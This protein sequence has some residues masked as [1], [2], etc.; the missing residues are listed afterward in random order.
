MREGQKALKDKVVPYIER[1]ASLLEVG[2]AVVADGHRLNF[3]VINPFTGKPCRAT[4]VA[5][6]DWKSWH[7]AGYVIMVEE[8]TQC[9]AAAQRN[10]IMNLGKLMKVWYTDNGKAFRAKYF[11]GC[12]SLEEAGLYG[13][14]ARLGII[15]IFARPYNAQAKIIERWNR[16]FSDTFERLF[17]SYT[18]SSILDKPAYMMRNEKFHKALHN[19]YVPTI[20]EAVDF[21]ESWLSFHRSQEC[22]NVKGKSIGAVFDEGRG[23]GVDPDELD[24]MMMETRIT[25]IDRNGIRFLNQNYY[26]DNLYGM[27]EQVVIKYSLFDLSSIKVFAMNGE[28]ICTAARVMPVHPLAGA[29]GAPADVTAVSRQIAQQKSAEKKTMEGVRELQRQGLVAQVD[30]QRIPESA[31]RIAEQCERQGIELA[32]TEEHIPEAAVVTANSGEGAASGAPTTENAVSLQDQPP[33]EAVRLEPKTRPFFGSN[34]ERYQW[35]LDF[36][37]WTDEDAAWCVWFRTTDEFRMLFAEEAAR[38]AEKENMG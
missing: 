36:G 2:D 35:H 33:A 15:H 4:L 22:P 27:R 34:I 9:I 30:W 14:S 17:P 19:E 20:E 24:D 10:C 12:K 25:R 18:G 29:L 23:P 28:Y 31:G 1:D 21:I 5:G 37:M 26:G 38:A 32:P 13:L 7:L 3:R 8:N 6:V 16:E 11:A